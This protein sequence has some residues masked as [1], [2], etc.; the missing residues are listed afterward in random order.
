MTSI[1]VSSYS[2][3]IVDI[4]QNKSHEYHVN[5]SL[6][7]YK[8]VTPEMLMSAIKAG[9]VFPLTVIDGNFSQPGQIATLG[10]PLI[11]RLRFLP[12]SKNDVEVVEETETSFKLKACANHIF[13]DS[14]ITMA[15]YSVNGELFYRIAGHGIDGE[16]RFRYISNLLFANL[17]LWEFFIQWNVTPFAQNLDKQIQTEFKKTICV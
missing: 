13:K 17:G 12:F 9:R 6:G 2:D 7:H 14:L 1:A 4:F 8:H 15:I 5:Q 3:R 11:N 10:I 16:N